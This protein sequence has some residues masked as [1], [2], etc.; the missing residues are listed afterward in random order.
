M[1]TL[2]RPRLRPYVVPAQ[3]YDDPRHVYLVDQLGLSP[4][5]QRMSVREFFWLR[6]FDGQRS[7]RDI[8]AEAMRQAGG[9][10]LPLEL[11]TDLVC[12]LEDAL[13]LEGPRFREVAHHAVREPRCVGCYESEPAALPRQL[14]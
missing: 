5:P 1:L 4:R 2:E 9:E 13:F 11:F 6:L 12:R 3:D 7:L 8:Q 10:V 14:D